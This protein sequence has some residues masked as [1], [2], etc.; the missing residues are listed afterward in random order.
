M[1]AD[2]LII[3]FVILLAVGFVVPLFVAHHFGAVRYPTAVDLADFD[4]NGIGAIA[5]AVSALINALL[6]MTVVIG[7]ASVREGQASR[8][9]QVLT[10]A[11]EQMD[12]VKEAE[13]TLKS[14]SLDYREWSEV[15]R[16]A[17]NRVCNAYQRMCYFATHGLINKEH[18]LDMWGVNICIY[19]KRLSAY[20]YSERERYNDH[21]DPAKVYLRKDFEII[22][23]QAEKHFAVKNPGMVDAYVS[24]WGNQA[25]ATQ[26]KDR[27]EH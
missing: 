8:A 26:E 16:L 12:S 25:V 7:F 23:K 4:W 27:T 10:W 21:R 11:A 9:A 19:W 14:A 13:R 6:I 20:V 22:A 3:V 24:S 17:A 2:R 5:A 18:F 1:K 15:E